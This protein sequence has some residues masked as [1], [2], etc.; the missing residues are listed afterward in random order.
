MKRLLLLGMI[1]SLLVVP[2]T[3]GAD[4]EEDV[5]ELMDR[6]DEL[7]LQTSKDR[8]SI[9]GDFRVKY[10]WLKWKIPAYQQMVGLDFSDTNFPMGIPVAMPV[11][12]AT[13][14]YVRRAIAGDAEGTEWIVSRFSP[15]LLA[16]AM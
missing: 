1:L 7:E 13:S 11:P 8:V 4:V 16:Q 15:L 12:D 2:A 14:V 3:A 9:F 6:V 5:E 10:D